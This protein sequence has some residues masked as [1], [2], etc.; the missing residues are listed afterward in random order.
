MLVLSKGGHPHSDLTR[1]VNGYPGFRRPPLLIEKSTV[2]TVQDKQGGLGP[3]SFLVYYRFVPEG[4]PRVPRGPMET[5]SRKS[6]VNYQTYVYVDIKHANWAVFNLT[7][8]PVLGLSLLS[9]RVYVLSPD[10]YFPP[11]PP[12]IRK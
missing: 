7:S 9:V 6:P 3:S 11:S 1:N 12:G 8:D 4:T 10:S 2:G 5:P